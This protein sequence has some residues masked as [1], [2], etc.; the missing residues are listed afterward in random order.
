MAI[1]VDQLFLQQGPAS[2]C[3]MDL[4]GMVRAGTLVSEG[5]K[6]FPCTGAKISKVALALGL[7]IQGGDHVHDGVLFRGPEGDVDELSLNAESVLELSSACGVAQ[8]EG[9]NG[10]IN[11]ELI[12]SLLRILAQFL[13]DI[14]NEQ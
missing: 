13:L 5:I 7:T 12:M 2:K 3:A 14:T 4:A 11:K 9:F 6:D 8:A 10:L 1:D